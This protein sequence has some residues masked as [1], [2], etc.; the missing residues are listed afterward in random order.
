[1]LD[2]A[3]GRY[4]LRH[5]VPCDA[6]VTDEAN[7]DKAMVIV[8]TRPGFWLPYVI[9]NAVEVLGY[10]LY[11]FGTSA[12]LDLVD[13]HVRGD[14]TRVRLP[15]ERMNTRQYS[16]LLLSPVFWER[17]REEHILIF[18]A[19]CLLLRPPPTRDAFVYDF[20]GPL[21]GDLGENTFVI[22]GG[23]SLRRKS[24][25]LRAIDLLGTDDKQSPED[26]AFTRTM[27]AHADRFCMPSLR[28]CYEFAI[29]SLG[30][31]RT[32]IGIHGTDK[33]YAN[34]GQVLEEFARGRS[35]ESR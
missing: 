11:V 7:R 28:R 1:M 25:M 32:A 13:R 2:H 20:I 6:T 21:C 5:E 27:R 17:I 9:A 8:E 23:L 19:D 16:E 34:A 33:Y 3:V 29:E 35:A 18:Q 4:L 24:G 31:V 12:V 10:N 26:V 22:N 30:D 15:E 14:F